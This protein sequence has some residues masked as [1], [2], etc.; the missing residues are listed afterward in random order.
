M[1][2][3]Q[4]AVACLSGR[5][6]GSALSPAD[7]ERVA[8]H[9][10]HAALVL[11]KSLFTR[12]PIFRDMEAK[13]IVA[14]VR[15]LRALVCLPNQLVVKQGAKATALCF[16]SQVSPQQPCALLQGGACQPWALLQRLSP[17]LDL[18]PAGR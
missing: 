6:L 14:F 1:L 3:D 17:A 5:Y 2:L 11:N 10:A 4:L 12:V 15:V 16:I 13:C 8:I 7:L 9:R 18:P